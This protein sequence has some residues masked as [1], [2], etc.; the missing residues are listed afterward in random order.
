[1]CDWCENMN[2][3]TERIGNIRI[4]S[5]ARKNEMKI[6]NHLKKIPVKI[7]DSRMSIEGI[8]KFLIYDM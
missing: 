2:Y 7:L 5:N 3:W 6:Y 4:A 8:N 1:M